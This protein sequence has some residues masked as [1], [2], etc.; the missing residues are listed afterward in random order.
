MI[1]CT[2]I[3]YIII[4][5]HHIFRNCKDASGNAIMLMQKID[6]TSCEESHGG[7]FHS[8]RTHYSLTH[9]HS[10]L[11][12]MM[13]ST[14]AKIYKSQATTDSSPSS[15]GHN[16][17]CAYGSKPLPQLPSLQCCSYRAIGVIVTMDSFFWWVLSKEQ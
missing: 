7:H 9:A 13:Q 15:S 5:L 17:L 6:T 1:S 2:N 14:L 3:S 4:H 12:P 11:A 16:H 10:Q 8:C